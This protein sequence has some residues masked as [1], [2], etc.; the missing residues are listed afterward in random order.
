MTDTLN[1]LIQYVGPTINPKFEK[2]QKD[3]R[4]LIL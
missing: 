3:I 2:K 4:L 1:F